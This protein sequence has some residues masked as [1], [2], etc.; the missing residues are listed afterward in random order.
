MKFIIKTQRDE[1]I[2][3]NTTICNQI[4]KYIIYLKK[5]IFEGST[6]YASKFLSEARIIKEKPST[7]SEVGRWLGRVLGT[8]FPLQTI[9]TL[10]VYLGCPPELDSKTYLRKTSHS[11]N[12]QYREI[13]Q[14][15]VWKFPPCWQGAVC[16]VPSSLLG[17]GRRGWL[18][19][20]RSRRST[21]QARKCPCEPTVL[22]LQW[23]PSKSSL[24]H[25]QPF[26]HQRIRTWYSKPDQ[27]PIEREIISLGGGS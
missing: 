2:I 16:K 18:R 5:K 1:K 17:R 13:K 27:K 25:L 24:M 23:G 10:T 21:G 4:K 20:F 19:I 7:V 22:L 14:K 15:L 3:Q 12:A 6:L 26:L 8:P 11:L 9:Q